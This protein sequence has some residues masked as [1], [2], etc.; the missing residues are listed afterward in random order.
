MSCRPGANARPPPP[1]AQGRAP[2]QR[3]AE[4]AG[5]GGSAPG[6]RAGVGRPPVDGRGAPPAAPG[7]ARQIEEFDRPRVDHAAGAAPFQIQ[8][9]KSCAKSC[10]GAGGGAR[11]RGWGLLHMRRSP[12]GG[13]GARAARVRCARVMPKGRYLEAA[14]CAEVFGHRGGRAARPRPACVP[15][16]GQAAPGRAARG[17][18]ARAPRPRLRAPGRR[19]GHGAW[20][21]SSGRGGSVLFI[22][23]PALMVGG[24]P[25]AA[26]WAGS[27]RTAGGSARG[28]RARPARQQE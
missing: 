16:R 3:K 28:W 17:G 4:G 7:G 26:P 5:L 2:S 21:G 22:H 10:Q 14:L 25:A 18:L 23:G 6:R 8:G 20:S 12:D 24:R 13:S 11:G 27:A 1:P 9:H 19:K 15:S